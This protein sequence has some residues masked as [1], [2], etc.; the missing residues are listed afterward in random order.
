[1]LLAAL[2]AAGLAAGAALLVGGGTAQ[3]A[4]PID[5]LLQGTFTMKGKITVASH[6]HGER[7]GKHVTRSWSF[8]P[9]C[10]SGGCASVVLK[11]FRSGS[12]VLDKIT[13]KRRHPGVYVGSH[14]FWLTLKCNGSRVKHGG[15]ANE[16][17]KVKIMHAIAN[18]GTKEATGIHAT[19]T[20]PSRYNETKCPGGIGH[21]AA[22]YNGH[23]NAT[24][25]AATAKGGYLILTSDGGVYN[26]GKASLHGSDAGK[27][28]VRVRAVG[29]AADPAGGGY[30]LLKSNGGVD[31]FDA[32]ALG[33]L[34]GK[35]HGT[36]PVAIASSPK[37]GYLILTSDGGVHHFGSAPWRGSD[38]GKLGHGVHAVSLAVNS[39]G[40]YWV[41]KSNG[42]VDA[43]GAPAAGSLRGKLHGAKPKSIAAAPSKGY[44]IL[45]SDGGV[46]GFGGSGWH[47][48]DQ[49][50]LGRGVRA[51]SLAA[52]PI[53]TGYWILKSNGA[54]DG[55]GAPSLGGL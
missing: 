55:F 12:H 29:I 45:T 28:E 11:R 13:L 49:G 5:A 41:L 51:I 15:Y 19:Y 44:W 38:R 30:W 37:G 27:L 50:K 22:T 2:A 39:S 4:H 46:H 43:F 48:S 47:G 21:D 26:F 31:A 34:S 16:T 54:V 36:H 7:P 3:A 25:L 1:V 42:G 14:R 9:S 17:I 40:G 24:S 10:S 18:G 35:L 23:L 6:V 20:N 33:S 8:Y 32:A 52:D 53:R